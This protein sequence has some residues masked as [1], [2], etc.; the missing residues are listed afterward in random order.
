MTIAP[1]CRRSTSPQHW[2]Y[3][4]RHRRHHIVLSHYAFYNFAIESDVAAQPR[5]SG[6]GQ[7]R[8]ESR[9][10]K[11]EPG[12]RFVAVCPTGAIDL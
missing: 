10:F 6:P 4:D 9:F 1:D 7:S 8:A 3:P 2:I 11:G 5:H 12:G